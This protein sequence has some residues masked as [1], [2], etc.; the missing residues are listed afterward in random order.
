MDTRMQ[1][2]L[3]AKYAN[4]SFPAKSGQPWTDEEETTLLEELKARTEIGQIAANHKRTTGGITARCKE[5]AYKMYMKHV[6]MDEIATLTQL[7][8]ECIQQVIDKK[9]GKEP[10]EK[11]KEKEI[12]SLE[13]D[14]QDMKQDLRTITQGVHELIQDRLEI[15]QR[16][17]E[18]TQSFQESKQCYQDIKQML[19]AIKNH[20]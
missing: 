10:K 3:K 4:P 1:K 17:H 11:D 6:P 13:K 14:I 15:K 12:T 9:Q 18:L 19:H 7:N 2:F 5:I 20:K 16:L 8:P